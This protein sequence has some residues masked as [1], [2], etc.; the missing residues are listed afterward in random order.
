M[1]YGMD[2]HLAIAAQNSFGT[3]NVSSW[4]FVPILSET[5]TTAIEELKEEAL[6]GRYDEGDS[7]EGLLTVAGDIVFEPHPIM[8]GHF[9]RGVTG[10]ASGVAAGDATEHEFIPTNSDFD[11]ELCALPPFSMEIYRGS[12]NAWQ[13]QDMIIN[14]LAIEITGGAI[15]R[16]TASVLCRVSSLA[17]AATP[18]FD[19]DAP[20]TWDAASISIAGAANAELENITLTIDNQIEGVTLCNATKL[21]AKYKRTGFRSFGVSGNIDFS[22]QTEYGMFRASTQQRMVV[23]LKGETDASSGYPESLTLDI[24]QLRYTSFPVNMGGPGRI[25]VGFEGNPKWDTSSSYSIR[26]TLINSRSAYV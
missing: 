4:D 3:I 11:I 1:G 9:L 23:H 25:S 15:V 5:V 20:W 24:P 14:A 16:A 7:H 19:T 17:A 10:Q 18:A 8:L 26:P 2:G 6:Q 12:G 22:N 21:H 13:F